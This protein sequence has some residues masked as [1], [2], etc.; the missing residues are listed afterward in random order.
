MWHPE[1]AVAKE[2]REVQLKMADAVRRSTFGGAARP[3]SPTSPTLPRE[4]LRF[5][6][7]VGGGPQGKADR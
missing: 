6:L 3:T 1:R 5:S 4:M 2:M 7:E